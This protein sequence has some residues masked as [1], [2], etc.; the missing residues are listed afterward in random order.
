M[1]KQTGA[2]LW[3]S[4]VFMDAADP[5]LIEDR[6]GV[7]VDLNEEAERDYGFSRD[8]L[9][10]KPIKTLVPPDR[11]A[12]ADELLARCLRGES[13]RNI[14]GQRWTR[15]EKVIPVL[16][17]LSALRDEVGNIDAIATLAKDVTDLKRVEHELAEAQ[18]RARRSYLER[19][20]RQQFEGPLLGNS[21]TVELLRERIDEAARSAE[22]VMLVGEPGSG[23]EA[24]ARAIHERSDRADRLF[25]HV[26]C[27]VIGHGSGSTLFRTG[28]E[29][30]TMGQIELAR[31]GTLFLH[32]IQHLDEDLQRQLLD[33][34][35]T[36]REPG[37]RIR[38]VAT[39][40]DGTT[41]DRQLARLIDRVRIRLPSLAE[42][43]EDVGVIAEHFAKK[44]AA[45][46]GKIVS[47]ISEPSLERLKDY[48]W[49]GNVDELESVI[50]RAVIVSHGE[51]LEVE[52][53]QLDD[54]VSMGSYKLME[55]VGAGAMGEV[56]TAKHKLL[57]R[58][59][60][61]KIIRSEALGEGQQA[62]TAVS[63]F[64]REAEMTSQLTSPH[65]V[66]LYDF[67][68]ADDGSFFYVMELLRGMDLD[69]II[70]Q[71]GSMSPSRAIPIIRQACR[72][73]AEAHAHGLVHRDIK[74][75]NLYLACLGGQ[76]DFVKVLDFG[77]VKT[78]PTSD[79]TKLTMA[80][81]SGGTPGYMAPEVA[82][83]HP[84][85]D[86][87]A[88]IYSLACSAYHLLTGRLVFEGSNA[89]STVLKHVQEE[90][91]APS[92]VAPEALP[93]GLDELILEC[94]AK[95]P[96]DRPGTAMK[97]H[98]R[99]GEIALDKPWSEATA[100]AWWRKRMPEALDP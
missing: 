42:R 9:I 90:P 32:G 38:L 75:A 48:R 34:L 14:E 71:Y 76:P 88:D 56:W 84:D 35:K 61:I 99:L 17:T 46:L 59:A 37:T 21:K 7:V 11:H 24:A 23:L 96:G 73:L 93:R 51:T 63:R 89:M 47:A 6:N 22:P 55:R 81:V 66:Q 25:V 36:S 83:G 44:H 58:P 54:Y 50:E 20:L 49:P 41:L 92:L 64:R 68:V 2:Q 100:L 3:H 8:E 77:L 28:D 52:D 65:T 53:S 43:L 67:G 27:A 33:E 5:I 87:R 86:G 82:T 69:R 4:K 79:S 31:G 26:H 16:L 97:L 40:P 80:G 1:T 45:R 91:S 78:D 74:P 10:G 98:Q 12:Q 70:A 94:L 57:A 18:E 39:V 30:D 85:I 95:A 29:I 72:S 62:A 19:Q 60:A 15:D 13:V